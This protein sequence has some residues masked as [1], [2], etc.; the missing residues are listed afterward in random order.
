MTACWREEPRSGPKRCMEIQLRAKGRATPNHSLENAC[1]KRVKKTGA[2]AG[3]GEAFK[4]DCHRCLGPWSCNP[5]IRHHL[6][7]IALH[8]SF[9]SDRM[10]GRPSKTV[11]CAQ[12]I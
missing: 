3:L 8:Q 4:I 6:I 10:Y 7:Y 5:K 12:L 1:L 11:R 2:Q 9:E